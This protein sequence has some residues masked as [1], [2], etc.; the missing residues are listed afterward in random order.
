MSKEIS[1]SYEQWLQGAPAY[2]GPERNWNEEIRFWVDKATKE[3][4]NYK[5]RV[6]ASQIVADLKDRDRELLTQWLLAQAEDTIYRMI[7][8]RDA[9]IRQHARIHKPVSMFSAA[10]RAAETG[11]TA[12]LRTWLDTPFTTISNVR[13]PLGEMTKAEVAFSADGYDRRARQNKMTGAFLRV[14]AR[15]LKDG[16]KVSQRFTEVDL[17]RLWGQTDV[18]E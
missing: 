10:A 13:K 12:A 5:A 6:L 17:D 9:S 1:H 4:G 3:A 14:L 16:Q 8:R 18:P 7:L 11:N 2:T 15:K